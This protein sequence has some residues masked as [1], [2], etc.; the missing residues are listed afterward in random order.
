MR[1]IALALAFF[2]S[3]SMASAEAQTGPKFGKN[4]GVGSS[5]STFSDGEPTGG[6]YSVN[7][8]TGDA[9]FNTATLPPTTAPAS[10]AA[11][12]C[13][14]ASDGLYCRNASA[15]VG[16]LISAGSPSFVQS[17]T[18]AVARSFTSKGQDVIDVRDF[19]AVCNSNGTSGNGNDDT[20]AI[21]AAITKAQP[22]GAE[23][24]LPPSVCRVT[25]QLTFAEG[26]SVRGQGF[27]IPRAGSSGATNLPSRGSWLFLDHTGV[28]LYF[29]NDASPNTEKAFSH[30][31]GFGTFR[32][33]AAPS[34][35]PGTP[36]TPTVMGEDILV[37][38]RVL[39]DRLAL[40]NPYT[41]V[42][43]RGAGTLWANDIFSQPLFQ[44]FDFERSA[45]IQNITN[46]HLW[47][48]WAQNQNV[49]DYTIDNAVGAKVRRADG[50]KINR[51]FTYGYAWSIDAQ[52]VTGDL[53]GFAAFSLNDIYADKAGGAI[54][55][56][57]SFYPAY[58]TI[59]GVVVNSDSAVGG[60]GA[61][62]EIAG[63]VASQVNILGLQV[64]RAHDEAVKVT[65]AAHTVNVQ[66]LKIEAWDRAA[67]GKYAFKTE[68]GARINLLSVPQ[69]SA[70]P[71]TLYDQ[72][73]SGVINYPG[74]F[75][76]GYPMA[77][78][79]G[80]QSARFNIAD[81]GVAVIAAPRSERTAVVTLTPT[82]TPASARPAGSYWM[83]ATGTPATAVVGAT[84]TTNVTTT[85]GVLTGTTGTD[86][87]FTI[88]A[89][90][91][92]NFYFENRSGGPVIYVVTMMGN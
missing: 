12:Q 3:L 48:F 33:Q 61:G 1:K 39:L 92:G 24:Q 78:G 90:S 56:T 7:G 18:G 44:G 65:G 85:T 79:Q 59:N 69:Y 28:G 5:S 50:L 37:E 17:G 88:S 66:A 77:S 68:D 27:F 58:G 82:A 9:T 70:S 22:I 86:G 35:T 64:T 62:I 45:D 87:N 54:R 71:T 14:N 47:P 75:Q 76:I 67:G 46:I 72:G 51:F 34:L 26:A 32:Q 10:P 91:N 13:W 36:W 15:T 74:F 73:T 6:T 55:L 25:S 38:G 2:A 83:R 4:G 23:I 49:Y 81:D 19:G 52:D 42:H 31:T 80:F 21:Q 20:A 41:G 40:L 57:S 89:A 16:P 30:L 84:T 43:V 29:R 8:T 11:G 60:T 63:A 53:S